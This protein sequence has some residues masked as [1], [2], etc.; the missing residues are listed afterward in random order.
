MFSRVIY[1]APRG[2]NPREDVSQPLSGDDLEVEAQEG[3]DEAVFHSLTVV[4]AGVRLGQAAYEEAL[5]CPEQPV[6]QFDLKHPD[7]TKD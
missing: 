5:V 2:G 4:D 1:P 6:I 3:L 7:R